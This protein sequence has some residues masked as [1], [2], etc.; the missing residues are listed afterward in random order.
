MQ[1]SVGFK[2][3][4]S[5]FGVW[6]LGFGVREFGSGCTIWSLGFRIPSVFFCTVGEGGGL[7]QD[8]KGHVGIYTGI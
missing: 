5:E 2:V 4:G 1:D 6:G 8:I 3:K 7:N